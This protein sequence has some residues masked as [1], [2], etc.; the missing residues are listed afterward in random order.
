MA[1]LSLKT[2]GKR[3]DIENS[4]EDRP[5][6]SPS[7]EGKSQP[8]ET[9]DKWIDSS[10][11]V[12]QLLWP[13][14]LPS[15]LFQIASGLSEPALALIAA[16]ID[17]DRRAIGAVVSARAIGQ[18]VSGVPASLVASR[19]SSASCVHLGGLLFSLAA[20]L[21]AV[22]TRTWHLLTTRFL[23]G[24]GFS[25]FGLP[26]QCV[27]ADLPHEVRGRGG[28]LIG[29]TMRFGNTIGPLMCGALLSFQ[30]YTSN[31]TNILT[32]FYSQALLA[33]P[34][35]FFAARGIDSLARDAAFTAS[36]T[37]PSK[38][39]EPACEACLAC[40]EAGMQV[41]AP[42][43]DKCRHK[44]TSTSLLSTQL[45]SKSGQRASSNSGSPSAAGPVDRTSVLSVLRLHWR[46]LLI[47]GP[48]ATCYMSLRTCRNLLI[49]LA[50]FQK[51]GLRDDQIG[52]LMGVVFAIDVCLLFPAG[53]VVDRLGRRFVILTSLIFLS[54]GFFLLWA[55][56]ASFDTRPW[57]LVVAAVTIGSGNGMSS[58]IV[59]TLGTDFAPP[60]GQG[61]GHFL[62]MFRTLGSA[63][64]VAGP[65]I[66]G[67]IA[68]SYSLRTAAL[69][70]ALSGLACLL[71]VVAFFED[72]KMARAISGP[73]VLEAS[74]VH[75]DPGAGGAVREGRRSFNNGSGG[76]GEQDR[77][78]G[79]GG[80][81]VHATRA[82]ERRA[83]GER[84]ALEVV[85][86]GS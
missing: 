68:Q 46:A 33:L 53:W 39:S 75:S 40:V 43:A 48:V 38:P 34:A 10:D 76:G 49:P 31:N 51:A 45:S 62:G 61:Q 77:G 7:R 8:V 28:A 74:S 2:G 56:G 78:E 73:I 85:K 37:A 17:N 9:S 19:L 84:L 58:G 5:L 24:V 57:L 50:G 32:I 63:G 82:E 25:L 11:V 20:I 60:R 81:S 41:D 4:D 29:G 69:C 44:P 26:R 6:L 27:L 3:N 67:F 72:S 23:A 83:T 36:P 65:V 21:S 15:L 16:S 70:V 14:L 47:G 55:M 59:M 22:S 12:R 30:R 64:A 18:L 13:L 71:H 79:V 52:Y 54:L 1:F 66:V 35:S 80:G 42:G 86:S